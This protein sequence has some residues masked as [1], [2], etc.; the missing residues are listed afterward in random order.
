MLSSLSHPAIS[1]PPHARVILLRQSW[2]SAR[3][4]RILDI[5]LIGEMGD[6]EDLADRCGAED[7]EDMEDS[8]DMDTSQDPATRYMDEGKVPRQ[9]LYFEENREKG[10]MVLYLMYK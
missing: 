7:M 3:T 8:D 2:I 4:E 6:I 5:T 9:A 10:C 1:A